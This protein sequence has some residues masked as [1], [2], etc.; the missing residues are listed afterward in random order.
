MVTASTYHKQRFF[1][2]P[3]KLTLVE[4]ALLET[5]EEYGWQVQAWAV[6]SNH[7]HFVGFSPEEG[8]NAMRMATKLHANTSRM[9]NRI[10]GTPGRKVWHQAWDTAI[11]FERSYMARLAYVHHNPVHH[12][13]VQVAEMYPW[14]SAEWFS[15]RADR[16]WY[17]TITSFPIKG[18][19]VADNY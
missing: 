17:E 10:D 18:V 8:S 13:L 6:F 1:D 5:L 14:C 2:T 4:D 15:Q 12:G 19:N 3:E 16:A 7:Y 9:V 11:S